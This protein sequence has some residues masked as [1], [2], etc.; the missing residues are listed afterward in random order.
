MIRRLPSFRVVVVVL[1]CPLAASASDLNG[2]EDFAQ[3]SRQGF[4]QTVNGSYVSVPGSLFPNLPNN[5]LGSGQNSYAWG[6]EWFARPGQDPALWV[7]TVRN[8]LC[9]L[10][11]GSLPSCPVPTEGLPLPLP[12]YT[13]DRAEIWRYDPAGLGGIS[14]AWTRVFQSPQASLS[15]RCA[16]GAANSANPAV[17][18]LFCT[19]GFTTA[20]SFPAH[21]GIR[22]LKA[23]D[24]GGVNRL[25][26]ANL[27]LFSSILYL[28][29]AGQFV[30]ASSAG[31][32]FSD[33]LGAVIGA[34]FDFAAVG[35]LDLG[36]RSLSCWER[37]DHVKVLCTAPA[38]GLTDPDSS[39]HPWVLCNANP[40]NTTSPWEPYSPLRFND[41]AAVGVFDMAV[42]HVAPDPEVLAGEPVNYLCASELDRTN[43]GTV[44]C[45]DGTGCNTT[46]PVSGE[47]YSFHQCEWTPVIANGAGRPTRYFGS[48]RGGPSGDPAAFGY[49]PVDTDGDGFHDYL[50]QGWAEAAG[51]PA[52]G[53]SDAELTRI[54]FDRDRPDDF[55][56]WEFLAGVPRVT[57]TP[58]ATA[59]ELDTDLFDLD[60][61]NLI[62]TPAAIPGHTGSLGC[63]PLAGRGLGFATSGNPSTALNASNGPASYFWRFAQHQG[64]LFMGVF[65]TAGGDLYRSPDAGVTWS[66]I[67]TNGMG[68]VFNGVPSNYGFRTM[69]STDATPGI[70]EAAAPTGPLSEGALGPEPEAVLAQPV[71]FVGT[72]NPY[73]PDL[74]EG[75][76]QVFM[77]VSGGNFPPVS[78]PGADQDGF[79]NENCLPA[80]P[81]DS[82]GLP[83]GNGTHTFTLGSGSGSYDPFGGAALTNYEWFTGA[84]SCNTVAS[85]SFQSATAVTFPM[86]LA[87][88][89]PFMAHTMTLRVTDADANRACATMVARAWAHRPPAVEITT[90]PPGRFTGT[91]PRVFL[92]DF[93]NNG[94]E[95]FKMHVSCRGHEPLASCTKSL[96]A[97]GTQ[98]FLSDPGV[99]AP[100]VNEFDVVV[101]LK[102]GGTGSPDID[103]TALDTH[104]APWTSGSNPY[105]VTAGIDAQ[106]LPFVDTAANDN[107]ACASGE[108]VA[109]QGV[110]LIYN[111]QSPEPGYPKL[112]EDPDP[113][114]TLT[115]GVDGG[116]DEANSAPYLP[117]SAVAG[118]GQTALHYTSPTSG[119][120]AFL[121]AASDGLVESPEVNLDLRVVYCDLS[122]AYEAVD[123]VT[124]TNEDRSACIA[125]IATDTLIAATTQF[126]AGE[127]VR[128]GEGFRVGAN[129]TFTAILDPGLLTP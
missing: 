88:A 21:I 23:C 123:G 121:F 44:W 80:T 122:V 24:A 1:L 63:L 55:M 62:C 78:V 76:A 73:G 70:N 85:P 81:F 39:P 111:P 35:E 112:C 16:L 56:K 22:N 82:C 113:G 87:S 69:V 108:V 38:A 8:L 25:Y 97:L 127:S 20:P 2:P 6:M 48:G 33:L 5:A 60:G 110:E 105:E 19:L 52:A 71:L 53:N 43:G 34:G 26:A 57:L 109:I 86:G 100:G 125:V 58:G 102:P 104:A 114:T 75:G 92:V 124:L 98:Y 14:G 94:E 41:P 95:S 54:V 12:D 37:P 10:S 101:T 74:P 27:G 129:A 59:A 18:Y 99:L 89:D 79:D 67:T 72:A 91:R 120:D 46:S 118:Q 4:S 51:G 93:D 64:D 126:S 96:Q 128:L 47:D 32:T 65:D 107:P 9:F 117:S 119:K 13:R 116:A 115:Y 90:V 3:I 84:V 103:V 28:N 49:G 68:W 50:V 83:T 45:T 7:G 106:I 15:T 31:A 42:V 77:G 11:P 66:T 36:Y 40:T 29:D 30:A 17:T 61:S